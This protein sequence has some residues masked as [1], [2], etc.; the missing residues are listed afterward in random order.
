[1]KP[2]GTK[3]QLRIAFLL[4]EFPCISETFILN[5]I[6]GLLDLGQDV[7][8]FAPYGNPNNPKQHEAI[9]KWGLLNKTK[10]FEPIP[11]GRLQR[12]SK[13]LRI[14]LQYFLRR[15]VRIW[16]CLNFRK[17]GIYQA[18]NHLFLLEPLINEDYDIIHCQY[19][20]LGKKWAHLKDIMN[21]S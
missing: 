21:T 4:N 1:M 15:P 14:L 19:G 10:Y 8:I 6:T 18:L 20:I 3:K 9:L 11:Q 2:R 13:F 16:K 17:Y 5:Q 12:L 7:H